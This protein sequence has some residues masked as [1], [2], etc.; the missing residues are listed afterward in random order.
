MSIVYVSAT[1]LRHTYPFGTHDAT[2]DFA[3]GKDLQARVRAVFAEDPKCRRVVVQVA[4]DNLEDIA[5]CER[6]GLRF[7]V[8]VE[9]RS[10][11]EIAL[12]VAEP[13]WVLQQP[14]EVED[15]ELN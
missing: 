10:R 7:V 13:D 8:N 5:A 4:Q 9:T 1:E 14:T 12:M 2:V 3:D 11:K 6:A 15:L